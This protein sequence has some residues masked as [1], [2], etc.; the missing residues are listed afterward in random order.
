MPMS[1]MRT[2]RNVQAPPPPL[3]Q[4]Q[5]QQQTS[6][7]V[8]QSNLI[9]PPPYEPNTSNTSPSKPGKVV[10]N[11]NANFTVN[12]F[13]FGSNHNENL[14]K[15]IAEVGHGSYFFIENKEVLG[16]AFVDC[17]G[18]LLSVVGQ[19]LKLALSPAPGVELIDVNTFYPK[20]REANGDI[21]L[22]IKDIQSEERRDLV[23]TVKLPELNG[24]DENSMAILSATL[25]YDNVL[26]AT[27]TTARTS[28]NLS[29][30]APDSA[31][32]KE[33]SAKP[34]IFVSEQSNRMVAAQRLKEAAN[35]ADVGSYKEAVARLEAG[36]EIIE[37][38]PA[39]ATPSSEELLASIRQSKGQMG[40]RRDYLSVGGKG[41][42]SKCS[43][44][45]KQRSCLQT[46]Q[47]ANHKK[48]AMSSAFKSF[49][50]AR[51]G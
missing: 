6:P 20:Q 51:R 47:F 36:I 35:L 15:G 11:L 16:D 26:T 32:C 4:Q 19:D 49:K 10:P 34:N 23:C 27:K 43:S 25:E 37:K 39:R 44:Y 3:Y 9:S 38:S 50:K 18:G 21:R 7:P 5:Q 28:L 29:R 24:P 17:I 42:R 14:L 22:T 40:N 48:S 1:P 12:T 46:P 8:H 30:P 45:S 33:A 2:S 41:A 31:D 13:G